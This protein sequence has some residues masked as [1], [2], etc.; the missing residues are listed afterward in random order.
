MMKEK[1]LNE[2]DSLTDILTAEKGLMKTYGTA[3][4]E[5]VGTDV[6]KTLKN[7]FSELTEEQY[8]IFKVMQKAG[9]YTP[10]PANKSVIDQKIDSCSKVLKEMKA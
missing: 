4:T 8:K 7:H 1:M 5:S 10:A 9:Y 3:L 6:R 2:K